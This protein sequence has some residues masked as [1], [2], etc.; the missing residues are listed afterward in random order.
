MIGI[1]N[2]RECDLQANY[3]GASE[4]E[5]SVLSHNDGEVMDEMSDG[6]TSLVELG[7]F[8]FYLVWMR[9]PSSSVVTRIASGPECLECNPWRPLS[10]LKALVRMQSA[11]IAGLCLR[12]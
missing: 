1:K 6:C 10:L 7:G 5:V 11:R 3:H 8:W 9:V 12:I 2:G 4:L